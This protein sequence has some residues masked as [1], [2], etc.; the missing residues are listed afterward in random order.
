MK[1]KQEVA[2]L[3]KEGASKEEQEAL[4][5]QHSEGVLSIDKIFIEIA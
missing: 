5:K 1:A 2:K 3:I 4:L